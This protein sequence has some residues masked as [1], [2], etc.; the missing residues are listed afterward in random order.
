MSESLACGFCRR[1]PDE[2]FRLFAGPENVAICDGCVGTMM[3]ILAAH[4]RDHFEKL[5]D[6]ARSFE[7]QSN[8]DFGN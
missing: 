6:A 5:V 4:H 8:D 7:P 2:V 1:S 3:L